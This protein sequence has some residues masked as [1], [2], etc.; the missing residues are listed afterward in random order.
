MHRSFLGF[1]LSLSCFAISLSE[2]QHTCFALPD[3]FLKRFVSLA[4]QV[5]FAKQK[6]E[7]DLAPFSL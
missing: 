6:R 2:Q 3:L 1:F 7:R 4:Y 5:S